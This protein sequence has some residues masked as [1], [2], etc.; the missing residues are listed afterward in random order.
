MT[1][2]FACLRDPEEREGEKTEEGLLP[3]RVVFAEP[4]VEGAADRR[5][6]DLPLSPLGLVSQRPE[7]LEMIVGEEA[8]P[9]RHLIHLFFFGS[10]GCPEVMV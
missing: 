5:L 3:V 4:P 8:Q 6:D 2:R 9:A 10:K 1:L 7:A